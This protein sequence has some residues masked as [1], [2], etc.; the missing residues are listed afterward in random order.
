VAYTPKQKRRAY[1]I[2]RRGDRKHATG[3]EKLSSLE[4]ALAESNLGNPDQAHSDGTSEGW[5]QETK[6]SYPNVNRRSIVGAAD[7]YFSETHG[8]RGKY[9][10][11]GA[12]AQ[13]VQRSAYPGRY[14]QYKGRAKDLLRAYE[15]GKLGKPGKGG[16]GTKTTGGDL[17]GKLKTTPGTDNSA[18]RTQIR[19]SYLHP[20]GKMPSQTALLSMAGQLSQAADVPGTQSLKLSRTPRKTVKTGG[21]VKDGVTKVALAPGADR[22]GVKTSH[23]LRRV[24]SGVKGIP[25]GI[26][27]TTGSN[28]NQ[29]TVNGNVSDHWSGHAAD[30]AVPVDSKRGDL[31]AGRA[32]MRLGVPR[33]QA[34][35]MAQQGGLFNVNYKGK[36]WQVIWK[37]TEG[38]NHHNHVHVGVS[39]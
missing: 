6:T 8:V 33:A 24:L 26:T 19:Q 7:R 21:G 30:I 34:R 38:G 27:I 14:N 36:R 15:Q 37:T 23:Y 10:D 32:L 12:L 31:I 22:P 3:T 2:L 9:R 13:A 28:H 4:T 18:L 39:H 35:H 5:R 17:T 11:A 16:G 25:G 20:G 29:M 1:L